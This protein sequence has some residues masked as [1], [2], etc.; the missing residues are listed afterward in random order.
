MKT[1][2][3]YFLDRDFL[4]EARRE[5][6]EF[7]SAEKAFLRKYMGLGEDTEAPPDLSGVPPGEAPAETPL[8]PSLDSPAEAPADVRTEAPGETPAEAP[9]APPGEAPPDSPEEAQEPDVFSQLKA[10]T[11]VQLVGFYVDGQEF[12]VPMQFVQEVVRFLKPT[13]LP[14]APSFI[15]GIVNLRGRITPLVRLR[16]LLEPGSEAGEDGFI[17]VCRS[18]GLQIGL[19]IQSLKTMYRIP[20][21]D[22]EWGVEAQLG[23]NVDYVAGLMK[24]REH[25]KLVGIISV[26]RIVE[27]VLKG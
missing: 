15:S 11:H 12:T 5:P 10:E 1:P 6:G 20:Q 19:M 14:A 23:A 27:K 22:I 7:T 4:R 2:E 21:E 25:G 26:D 16:E 9:D 8:K 13:K 3:E 17:V 18:K 24:S